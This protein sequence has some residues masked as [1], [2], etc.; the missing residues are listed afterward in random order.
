MVCAATNLVSGAA[1][2]PDAPW[3]NCDAD[4]SILSDA[5]S[6]DY[7]RAVAHFDADRS[8]FISQD[9][10]ADAM[11]ALRCCG[12][13]CPHNSNCRPD[14]VALFPPVDSSF[15]DRFVLTA[16]NFFATVVASNRTW[17]VGSP[18]G[19]G[20]FERVT[21]LSPGGGAA[22]EIG[23][24]YTDRGEILV[25]VA[26]QAFTGG[27]VGGSLSGLPANEL[28]E[29]AGAEDGSAALLFQ[30]R[31]KPSGWRLAQPDAARLMQSYG[32]EYGDRGSEGT[33][34]LTIDVQGGPGTPRL[35]FVYSTSRAYLALMPSDLRLVSLGLM[36][37]E[38]IREQVRQRRK[39][40]TCSAVV[41]PTIACAV[42]YPR[43]ERGTRGAG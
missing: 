1:F 13:R 24:L 35:R 18:G 28:A 29:A 43:K 31:D 39:C 12:S 32:A 41:H 8:Q 11:T 26:Q 42:T 10:A 38:L 33:A 17:M 14:T 9:E 27:P 5:F 40:S 34:F 7:N 20:C 22:R 23:S 30:R 16:S 25:T 21:A 36:E 4:E 19:G 2:V 15:F 3:A 37:P 6:F